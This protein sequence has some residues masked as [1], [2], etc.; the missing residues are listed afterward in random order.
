MVYITDVQLLVGWQ[1]EFKE[2]NMCSLIINDQPTS[3]LSWRKPE[4][5]M[6]FL[7]QLEFHMCSENVPPIFKPYHNYL[8]NYLI[9]MSRYSSFLALTTPT[10]P[11]GPNRIWMKALE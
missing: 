6:G 1:G 9:S 11:W 10:V 4:W 8:V 3:K 5:K 2:F 7:V